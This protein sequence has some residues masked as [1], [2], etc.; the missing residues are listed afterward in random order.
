M[1]E[2]A[3]N[4]DSA[5]EQWY[6]RTA[7]LLDSMGLPKATR[8]REEGGGRREEGRVAALLGEW[9][10][11]HTRARCGARVSDRLHHTRARRTF[12]DT[13]AAVGCT[14]W[15]VVSTDT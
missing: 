9:R 8:R 6:L 15:W 2:R 13:A 14:H 5:I 12:T 1:L 4:S 11:R 3:L 10:A 7:D